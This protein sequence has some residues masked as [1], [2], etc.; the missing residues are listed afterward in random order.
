MKSKLIANGFAILT[1]ISIIFSSIAP[2]GVYAAEAQKEVAK[3]PSTVVEDSTLGL[4]VS[5]GGEIDVTIAGKTDKVTSKNTATGRVTK[6]KDKKKEATEVPV[7]VGTPKVKDEAKI[8]S[9][10]EAK[11]EVKA[12]VNTPVEQSKPSDEQAKTYGI[13]WNLTKDLLSAIDNDGKTEFKAGER[14]DIYF[15]FSG[16]TKDRYMRTISVTDKDGNFVDFRLEKGSDSAGSFIMPEGGV[17]ITATTTANEHSWVSV[18]KKETTNPVLKAVKSLFVIDAKAE[19]VELLDYGKVTYEE[20]GLGHGNWTNQFQ[21]VYKNSTGEDTHRWGFCLNP[22]KGAPRFGVHTNAEPYP[23]DYDNY[24]MIY[25]ALSYT[26]DLSLQD[27]LGVD[28]MTAYT[29]GHIAIAKLSGDSHWSFGI[30]KR[31]RDLTEEALN[32]LSTQPM[33]QNT[34]DTLYWVPSN[35]YQ[36][37]IYMKHE[38]PKVN[39]EI[40]V[41]KNSAQPNFTNGNTNY[42]MAG[43]VYGIYSDENATQEVGR[44]TIDANGNS[45]AVTVEKNVGEHQRYFAR[46]I[47]APTNG[48]WELDKTIYEIGVDDVNAK[49]EVKEAPKFATAKIVKSDFD[50]K[51]IKPASGEIQSFMGTEYSVKFYKND[52]D[53][54]SGFATVQKD[55]SLAIRLNGTNVTG[56]LPYG[57][58]VFKET[59]AIATYRLDP[60][61][62][63][64]EVTKDSIKNLGKDEGFAIVRGDGTFYDKPTETNFNKENGFGKEVPGAKICIKNKEGKVVE[65]W[66]STNKPHTIKGLAKGQYT[67]EETQAP[68]GYY[69]STTGKFEVSDKVVTKNKIVDLE[70]KAE[71]VKKNEAGEVLSGGKFRL[72]DNTDANKVVYEWTSSDKAEQLGKYL[73]ADHNYTIQETEAPLGYTIGADVM[74]HVE[75]FN[76]VKNEV[77][78]L[79]MTDKQTVVNFSKVDLNGSEISGAKLTVKTKDGKVVDSWTSDGKTHTLTGKLDVNKEYVMHEE[80]APRGYKFAQDIIFKMDKGGEIYLM[81]NGK[82]TKASENLVKMIDEKIPERP[83]LTRFIPT[84]LNSSMVPFILCGA[85]ALLLVIGFV[86]YRKKDDK[87]DEDN[88]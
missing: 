41:H 35:K 65:C 72:V 42:S 18:N 38:Q 7:K 3:Q 55:G 5:D 2:M 1:A 87:D 46:E 19:T 34:G 50:S 16:D 82:W 74:F 54:I 30:N 33:P 29:I 47:S 28:R 36:D 62:H 45:S 88:K 20:M 75:K 56:N 61:E 22:A 10:G 83:Q 57:K 51:T 76:P 79:S 48:V 66:T 49:T 37:I 24:E 81:S 32:W 13:K 14:V 53:M 85:A 26:D 84:G 9:R 59:K 86:V 39:V 27:H 25:K 71:F 80:V 8:E 15:G 23:T 21:T 11:T 44:V 43:A 73:T 4:I 17:T 70:I 64:I 52:K 40:S 78:S 63:T 67:F 12:G 31:A 6:V 77:I 69:F 60:A 68:R 58:Y